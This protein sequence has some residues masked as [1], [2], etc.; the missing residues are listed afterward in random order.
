MR[1]VRLL[2]VFFAALVLSACQVDVV[3]DVD[4]TED[5]SGT[6]TLMAAFDDEIVE[7]AP[8]LLDGLRTEDLASAG[9]TVDGPRRTEGGNAVVVSATKPFASPD[10]LG[11]VLDEI[12][13]PGT[14]F[15]DFTVER[16]R[17]FARTTYNVTGKI[18]PR[19][20]FTTFGDD[21]IAGLVGAPLGL[22]LAEL[23]AAAGRPLEE[24][25]TLE[26][27]IT[28]PDTVL[29]NT[30]DVEGTVASWQLSP[31]DPLATD[32][33]VSSSIE[34]RL[35]RIWAAVALVAIALLGTLLIF[36]V[37]ARFG[38]RRTDDLGEEVV[39][40]RRPDKAPS[41]SSA[42]TAPRER[43]P[44]LELVVL[45]ARGVL[46]DE[47]NDIGARLVPFVRERGSKASLQE[48][49]DAFRSA[50][51]GRLSTAELWT[52]L[53]LTDD[54]AELDALYTAEFR[55]RE[56]VLDFIDRLHERGLRVAVITNNVLG[57][58][59]AI[60]KRFDLDERVDIWVVSGE[61]G[62]RK[63]DAAFF[64]A[65]RRMTSVEYTDSLLIDD[66]IDDLDMARSL[67]MSTAMFVPNGA[68]LPASS[69]HP[70]VHGFDSFFG[71]S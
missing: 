60:R 69:P 40:M 48:I 31:R 49:N 52:D 67:N 3:V 8:E 58:S 70:I 46:Y 24:T 51:L 7:A 1:P 68:Q 44:R 37:L 42:V 61:I 11:G 64:E 54:P 23:Q 27:S 63:P 14:L 53:G 21:N 4:V 15:S 39:Q 36:R 10:D 57:W 30:A 32:I 62:S 38:G 47:A 20:S 41:E 43:P 28:L 9:W 45:D 29:A 66:Q 71:R 12:A 35:P 19:I 17:S 33:E 22:S 55:L 16:T 6:V 50:S 34:D 59:K 65:L 25:V 18:N 13:G 5:G 26:F 2:L 56:G